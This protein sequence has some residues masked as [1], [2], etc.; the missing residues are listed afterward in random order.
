M[1]FTLLSQKVIFW[2]VS[3]SSRADGHQHSIK[4]QRNPTVKT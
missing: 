2:L 3:P 1:N 4:I